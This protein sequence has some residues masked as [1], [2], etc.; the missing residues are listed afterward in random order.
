MNAFISISRNH[1][2]EKLRFHTAIGEVTFVSFKVQPHIDILYEWVTH[3]R[4]QYWGLQN[5]TR[6]QVAREYQQLT[7]QHHHRVLLGYVN[8]QPTF[9]LEIYDPHNSELKHKLPLKLGDLGLHLLIAPCSHPIHNFSYWI[10]HTSMRLL[11]EL[12]VF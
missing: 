3:S 12:C 1:L 8:Q 9:I 5:A 7:Q 6:E 4:A 2:L 10:M 11:F